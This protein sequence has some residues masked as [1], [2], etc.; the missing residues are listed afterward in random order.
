MKNESTSWSRAIAAMDMTFGH[1][2]EAAYQVLR[3]N[4]E[5][6][7]IYDCAIVALVETQKTSYADAAQPYAAAI[8]MVRE[9]IEEL[10]GPAANIE[11]EEAVL[12]RGPEPHH[13]AEAII[14]ALQRV[15]EHSL[16]PALR[17]WRRQNT[18]PGHE[19]YH[20]S[21]DEAL[22]RAINARYRP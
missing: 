11:S 6:K 9:A 16:E 5:A 18:M 20:T 17:E 19:K 3:S 15:K 12:L 10:F 8:R 13:D 7:R 21:Y 1:G 4:A 2:R 14:A 22:L